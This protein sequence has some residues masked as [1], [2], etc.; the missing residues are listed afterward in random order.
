MGSRQIYQLN[1][2]Q[3]GT[4]KLDCVGQI[5]LVQIIKQD[6][7][8]AS[9]EQVEV[10]KQVLEQ[11]KREIENDTK[12]IIICLQYSCD[13]NNS[14][15]VCEVKKRSRVIFLVPETPGQTIG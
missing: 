5:I 13:R 1:E 10:K 14:E 11:K 7:C 2:N 4:V 6:N 3:E 15:P 9:D 8:Q 12:S